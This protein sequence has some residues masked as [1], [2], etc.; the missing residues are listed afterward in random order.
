MNQV[1][2]GF[3]EKT[4]EVDVLRAYNGLHADRAVTFVDTVRI[5]RFRRGC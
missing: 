3:I 5:A 1:S 4:T 2:A